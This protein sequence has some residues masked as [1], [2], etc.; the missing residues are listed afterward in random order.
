MDMSKLKTNIL[1]RV[2]NPD[3]YRENEAFKMHEVILFIFKA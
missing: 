2:C 3:S 1:L